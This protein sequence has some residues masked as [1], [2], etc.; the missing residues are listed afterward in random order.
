MPPPQQ[1]ARARERAGGSDHRF[2]LERGPLLCATLLKQSDRQHVLLLTMH[3]I[4]SDGWSMAVPIR[5]LNA[6]YA[7]LCVRDVKSM[8]P[9][10]LGAVCG[11]CAVAAKLAARG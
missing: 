3:H 2:D 4:V 11:F 8:L 9:A 5:E 10:R 6:L 7:A 1:A